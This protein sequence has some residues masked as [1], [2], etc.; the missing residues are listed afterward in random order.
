MYINIKSLGTIAVI[1]CHLPFHSERLFE[2][3]ENQDT[4]LQQEKMQ[5]QNNAYNLIYRSL[6]A[7]HKVDY[8]IWMGDFNYR[9]DIPKAE[10]VWYQFQSL[11]SSELKTFVKELYTS[12]DEL[13]QQYDKQLIYPLSEGV[14]SNGPE[15]LP[16][17]KM[18]K[19][20][21]TIQY[22]LGKKMQRSPSWADR[23]LYMSNKYPF[24]KCDMYDRWCEGDTMKKSDHDAVIAS[25]SISFTSESSIFL[26]SVK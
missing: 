14:D 7:G 6:I 21:E 16:T 2:R 12:H 26:P 19:E 18:K 3:Q 22:K 24:M 15:F 4:Y 11:Q 13:F 5:E 20:R 1:N 23:I 9:L 17:C 10:L 8:V 25:F